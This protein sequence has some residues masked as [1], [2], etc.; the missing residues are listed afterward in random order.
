MRRRSC[1]ATSAGSSTCS[2]TAARSCSATRRRI[3]DFSAAQSIWFVRRAPPVATRAR[4]RTGADRLVRAR[5]GASAMAR[6]SRWRATRRSRLRAA[7]PTASRRAGRRRREAFAA[8]AEVS[9]TPTDYAHDPVA[10]RLVGLDDDEVVDRARRRAR[11]PRARA[12]SAH[13]LSSVKDQSMKESPMK[14]FQRPH[15]RH[16]RRRLGL[17][18]RGLAHRRAQAA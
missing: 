4:R 3:A 2:P 12:L 15:R 18:P 5:A 9:V 8:G 13:R 10:G 14:T 16:H 17:R 7:A 6:T 11:R 1:H